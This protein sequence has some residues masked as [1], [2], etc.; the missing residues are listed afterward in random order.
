VNHIRHPYPAPEVKRKTIFD[1]CGEKKNKKKIKIFDSA[2]QAY[3]L[4][5]QVEQG[6]GEGFPK[7]ASQRHPQ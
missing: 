6:Q 7:V 4:L 3:L 2:V 1:S 5:S